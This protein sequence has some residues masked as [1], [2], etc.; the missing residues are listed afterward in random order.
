M[1]YL[2]PLDPKKGKKRAHYW[3]E[4]EDV[5]YCDMP[6]SELTKRRWA[7]S[8][9]PGEHLICKECYTSRLMEQLATIE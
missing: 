7:L 2:V 6:Q 3:N 9:S 8:E 4:S 1:K 5:T